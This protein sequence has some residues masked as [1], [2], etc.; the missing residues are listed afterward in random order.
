MKRILLYIVLCLFSSNLFSQVQTSAPILLENEDRSEKYLIEA[1]RVFD[2]PTDYIDFFIPQEFKCKNWIVKY[3]R[4]ELKGLNTDHFLYAAL[5]F[6]AYEHERIVNT[7]TYLELKCYP[8]NKCYYLDIKGCNKL[9]KNLDTIYKQTL[10]FS[11]TL[12][13]EASIGFL[14]TGEGVKAKREEGKNKSWKYCIHEGNYFDEK[15]CDKVQN[16][17]ITAIATIRALKNPETKIA[18]YKAGKTE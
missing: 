7:L 1:K 15:E 6:T 3:E 10:A 14:N 5:I 13:S 17:L 9:A 12:A 11:T 8:A 16:S 4:V 18:T 2:V